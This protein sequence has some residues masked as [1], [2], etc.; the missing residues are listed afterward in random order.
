MSDPEILTA[1]PEKPYSTTPAP[2]KKI[3]LFLIVIALL[4]TMGMT[5][6]GPVVPFMTLKYLC[7]PNDLAVVVA[8][9]VSL[10][11]ICQLLVAPGLGLLSDR[12]GRRPVL[13]VC[14]LG[15]AIGYLLFGLGGALWMLFLGRV[16]DGLTGG[17]FSVLFAYI[18]DITEPEER[19]KYFGMVGGFSGVG[20]ILGPAIGGLLA[21]IS[22]STPFLAATAVILCTI[23]W[24][25][26]F[27]PESLHKE[28]RVASLHLS[29]LNPFKQMGHVF[30]LS[31]LRWLLLAGFFYSLP[32]AM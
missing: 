32:F 18:A 9:M 6:I 10:Y 15:S 2:N 3:V 31:H 4:N 16:I 28:H 25:Y 19:G 23:I 7:N 12:F 8:W 24:G 27:L 21:G 17:N 26:F 5:I 20:F 14:L 22:Y 30:A 13:F 29:D 1:L 11:G